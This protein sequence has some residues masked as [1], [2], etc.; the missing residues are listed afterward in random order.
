MLFYFYTF[1]IKLI[2][3]GNKFKYSST[4]QNGKIFPKISN[5]K[6][7]LFNKEIKSSKYSQVFSFSF[8]ILSIIHLILIYFYYK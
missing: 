7:F 8:I 6:L 5:N 1:N 4:I 3:Y 2:K